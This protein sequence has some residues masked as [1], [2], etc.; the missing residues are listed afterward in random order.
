[1]NDE[2]GESMEV[3]TDGGSATKNELWSRRSQYIGWLLTSIQH[4]V[5]YKIYYLQSLMELQRRRVA[6]SEPECRY[7]T[8]Q[9]SLACA[10]LH[11]SHIIHRDLKLGNLFLDDAMRVK[12]GDFGLATRLDRDGERKLYAPMRA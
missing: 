8:R 4:S 6:V 9:V 12:L 10:Y 5:L 1:M 11:R 2:S 7:F 3:G